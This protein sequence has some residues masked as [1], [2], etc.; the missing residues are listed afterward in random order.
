MNNK[1]IVAFEKFKEKVEKRRKFSRVLKKADDKAYA[2][3]VKRH[4]NYHAQQDNTAILI[5]KTSRQ[6]KK[7]FGLSTPD[8]LDQIHTNDNEQYPDPTEQRGDK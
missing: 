2:V 6:A 5:S 1:Q 8:F 4:A 7:R 3:Y